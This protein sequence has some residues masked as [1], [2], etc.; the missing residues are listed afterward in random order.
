[1]KIIF[2]I[3]VLIFRSNDMSFKCNNESRISGYTNLQHVNVNSICFKGGFFLTIWIKSMHQWSQE[4]TKQFWLRPNVFQ[5]FLVDM[6]QINKGAYTSNFI[7]KH[8][9][10]TPNHL[11]K[12]RIICVFDSSRIYLPI[13]RNW[14]ENSGSNYSYPRHKDIDISTYK[15]ISLLFR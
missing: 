9:R 3:W 8:L 15:S 1:M 6:K 12:H 10:F 13:Y 11:K 14:Q 5:H 4:G 7:F 2:L